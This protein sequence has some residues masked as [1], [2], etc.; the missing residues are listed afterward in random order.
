MTGK[1]LEARSDSVQAKLRNIRT[2][3]ETR[4]KDLRRIL[5]SDAAQVRAEFAKHIA[6]IT[7]T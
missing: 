1:L 7:M 6:K 5:N 4:M 2:L 3:V